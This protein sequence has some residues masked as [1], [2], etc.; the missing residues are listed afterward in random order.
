MPRPKSN[1]KPSGT[2]SAFRP[3]KKSTQE[4]KHAARMLYDS[5]RLPGSLETASRDQIIDWVCKKS[6]VPKT[7]PSPLPHKP[8]GTEPTFTQRRWITTPGVENSNCYSYAMNDFSANRSVKA[9]PGER[10]GAP[11]PRDFGDC[12]GWN[13]AVVADNPD[14]VTLL[15]DPY[16]ACPR[17][18]FKIMLFTTGGGGGNQDFHFYR[19]H[20]SGVWSHKRGHATPP[21]IH[22]AS[23]KVIWDPL[24]ADRNYGS[25]DYRK[26]CGAFCVRRGGK[27][28]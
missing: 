12:K 23:G 4:L 7:K 11:A 22:D 17:N 3:S 10:V 28:K 25:L 5:T 2:C 16:A 19:M 9:T 15:S 13:E 27:T 18:A 24:K 6:T 20:R 8:N 14:H 21:L 26:F 1:S